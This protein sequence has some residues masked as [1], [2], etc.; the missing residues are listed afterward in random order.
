[1][2]LGFYTGS[3]GQI[4]AGQ[5]AVAALARALADLNHEVY[6]LETTLVRRGPG[7]RD[8]LLFWQ[9][10][11]LPHL[12]RILLKRNRNA[13]KA[14][15]YDLANGAAQIAG[16]HRLQ[17][18]VLYTMHNTNVLGVLEFGVPRR[19]V[20]VMNLVGFG[21]DRE[22]GG[23]RDTF[24]YQAR[25]FGSPQ[26]DLHLAAT[27][28]EYSRYKAVYAGLGLP[29]SKLAHLSYGIN[30]A[31]FAPV[32][33]QKRADIRASLG[34][35]PVGEQLVLVY[36]VNVYRR[37]NLELAIQTVGLLTKIKPTVLIITGS[38]WDREYQTELIHQESDLGLRRSVQFLDGVSEAR[39][40]ELMNA[41]DAT[42]FTSHQETF[43]LGLVESLAC[44]TPTVGPGWIPPCQEIL[45]GLPGSYAVPD[46]RAEAMARAVLDSVAAAHDRRHISAAATARYGTATIAPQFLALVNPLVCQKQARERKLEEID[47][48]S[49][50]GAL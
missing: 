36:P 37:K 2:R 49:L 4:G 3:V 16:A 30:E 40:V 21:I 27:K 6:L 50:Y 8:G 7:S 39:L 14:E 22:R 29:D 9:E 41:S 32:S 24:P 44:G 19:L 20:F 26:W 28:F 10:P 1:M 38:V 47:W 23:Q 31:V 42:I 15:V 35:G 13:C 5:T 45:S 46:K 33:P 25:I 12:P 17:L 48:R 11:L 34:F 43:G 18:D